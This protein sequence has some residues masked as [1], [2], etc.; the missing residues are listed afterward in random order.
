MK[1]AVTYDQGM[2]FQHFGH[3][4]EFKIYTIKADEIV[5]SQIIKTNGTGHCALA[6]V[7]SELG[8]EVLICGGIGT[9]AINNLV[10][11]GIEILPGVIPKVI[12]NISASTRKPVV[13]G[14]LIDSKDDVIMALNAGATCVSTSKMEIWQM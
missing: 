3:T 13:A 11:A 10:R 1:I 2:I 4:E 5:E 6:N 9:G 8:V 12:K 14:G 7:L